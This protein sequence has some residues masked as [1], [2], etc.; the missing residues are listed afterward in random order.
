MKFFDKAESSV[1]NL[2]RE[3]FAKDKEG[4]LVPIYLFSKV[5][6]SLTNGLKLIGVIRKI[7]YLTFEPECPLE[8]SK[9]PQEYFLCDQENN[10]QNFSYGM[11]TSFGLFPKMFQSTNGNSLFD[12]EVQIEYLSNDI[13]DKEED[14]KTTGSLITIDTARLFEKVDREILSNEEFKYFEE[15]SGSQRVFCQM[16]EL[17]F[18]NLAFIKIFRII[19]YAKHQ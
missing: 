3:L 1:L 13:V 7:D 19:D 12:Q 17:N 11:T 5:L 8:F 15:K 16:V 6:P 10:I 9:M 2:V 14:L 4:Y 18:S